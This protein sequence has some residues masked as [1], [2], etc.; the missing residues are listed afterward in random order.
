MPVERII[1]A[2]STELFENNGPNHRPLQIIRPQTSKE[3]VT[4]TS[5]TTANAY[6]K[7]KVKVP[8][9]SDNEKAE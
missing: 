2:E 9:M 4:S 6:G 1:R 3:R 8:K 5:T 7:I